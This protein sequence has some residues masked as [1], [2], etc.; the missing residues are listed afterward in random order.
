MTGPSAR[1]SELIP[2]SWKNGVQG[3]PIPEDAEVTLGV[4]LTL[5]LI[6]AITAP[7]QAGFVGQAG[8]LEKANG[9]TLDTIEIVSKCEA[10]V[11]ASRQ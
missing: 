1:C 4:P 9:R 10:R 6:V 5:A 2:D 8:Q 7:W 11:N 3:Q